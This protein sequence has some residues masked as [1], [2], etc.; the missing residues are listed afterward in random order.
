[1]ASKRKTSSKRRKSG[2]LKGLK[3]KTVRIKGG[4]KKICRD[5]KGRI[6]AQGKKV[7][8]PRKATSAR[9]GGKP[10]KCPARYRGK[11]VYRTK[12]GGCYIKLKSGRPR[13]VKKVRARRRRR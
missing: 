6:R 8:S 9:G 10:T 4:Y 13:F 5:A 2:G 11:K 1:M 3:C 12:R 7:S